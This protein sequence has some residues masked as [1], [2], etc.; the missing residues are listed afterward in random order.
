MG[1]VSVMSKTRHACW[2]LLALMPA[3]CNHQDTEALTRIGKKVQTQTEMVTGQVKTNAASSW[4]AVGDFGA[5]VRVATRLRWDK[6]LAD[7]SI[8]VLASGTGVELRGKVFN[9]DQR[10][11]AVML[12]ETTTGVVGVKD[13]LVESER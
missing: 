10:R 7:L 3:G 1:I 2:L 11:R 4:H 8:D 5:D 13:S 6:D 12:A 9:L